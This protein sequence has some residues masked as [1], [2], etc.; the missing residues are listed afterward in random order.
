MSYNICDNPLLYN[1]LLWIP[2]CL[3]TSLAALL[4]IS[5]DVLL[6]RYACEHDVNH[7]HMNY[8]WE[9]WLG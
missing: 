6:R 7:N 9:L 8:F 2:V 3:V 4:A 1:L 5:A